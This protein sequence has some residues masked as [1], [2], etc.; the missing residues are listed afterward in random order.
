MSY[1]I[2]QKNHHFGKAVTDLHLTHEGVVASFFS[3]ETAKA[4]L[5][6]LNKIYDVSDFKILRSDRLPGRLKK[7]LDNIGAD[8]FSDYFTDYYR[9]LPTA[10]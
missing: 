2:S 7:Q 10:A 4:Y 8:I 3:A 6:N 9:L 5:Y 1:V